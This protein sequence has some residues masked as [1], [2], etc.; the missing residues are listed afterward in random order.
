MNFA[1]IVHKFSLI[2]KITLSTILLFSLPSRS[3]FAAPPAAIVPAIP[4]GAYRGN[5]RGKGDG[6]VYLISSPLAG[7]EGCFM[8]TMFV[9]LKEAIRIYKAVPRDQLLI[10]TKAGNLAPTSYTLTPI[11]VNPEGELRPQRNPSLVITIQNAE[12]IG[13]EDVH[14]TT[15]QANSVNPD[16]FGKPAKFH[17]ESHRY[18]DDDQAAG[19]LKE[20]NRGFLRSRRAPGWKETG[21]IGISSIEVEDGSHSATITD[22]HSNGIFYNEERAPG[23]YTFSREN[24]LATGSEVS[25]TPEKIV[26]FIRAGRRHRSLFMEPRAFIINPAKASDVSELRVNH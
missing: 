7:C 1:N 15:V 11:G 14:F 21:T 16:F 13:T 24:N 2:N 20:D 19:S 3:S 25:A 12:T 9:D 26:V 10:P 22:Y 23:I 18:S 6:R 8:A 4:E 5:F 17:T